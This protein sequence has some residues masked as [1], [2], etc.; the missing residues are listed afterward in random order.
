MGP[1]SEGLYVLVAQWKRSD[2]RWGTPFG[3]RMFPA[4]RS[5]EELKHAHR[6]IVMAAAL[7]L[8][9]EIPQTDEAID[10]ASFFI[11]RRAIV[12]V[13]VRRMPMAMAG[14]MMMTRS[15]GGMNPMLM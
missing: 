15:G 6:V 1:A 4:S 2:A 8:L 5:C 3:R 11:V 10:S 13:V 14:R 12:R 7:R 9:V